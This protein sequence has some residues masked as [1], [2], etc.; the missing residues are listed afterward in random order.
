MR[1]KF[2]QP[3]YF[4]LHIT[5]LCG[6]I[7]NF[8]QIMFVLTISR[9][10]IP[11][12]NLYISQ[13]TICYILNPFNNTLFVYKS[14]LDALIVLDRISIFKQR[15]REIYSSYSPSTYSFVAFFI[16][17]VLCMNHIW[18]FQPWK[19]QVAA[20][21]GDLSD[22]LTVGL[23]PHMS[24]KKMKIINFLLVFC[25]S[26]VICLADIILNVISLLVFKKFM[27]RKNMILISLE[28]AQTFIQQQ[29]ASD[30]LTSKASTSNNAALNVSRSS[31]E[32]ENQRDETFD[33][34]RNL[35][36]MVIILCTVSVFH[37]LVYIGNFIVLLKTDGITRS[38]SISVFI[39]NL[40][41]VF[42]FASNFFI[43][44]LFN[45]NFKEEFKKLIRRRH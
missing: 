17:L 2:M 11:L 7:L 29:S 35:S 23:T 36:K 27:S 45:K 24:T 43:Y 13:W 20:S 34:E 6:I 10:F 31:N 37:Q 8:C 42:R 16:S 14:L 41:S 26:V 22:F 19:Y 33:S 32:F 40:V 28:N 15:V 39:L 12:S 5:T 38:S 30:V 44:Y 18:M 9:Q 3:M 4:Y 21:N 25:R 1:L